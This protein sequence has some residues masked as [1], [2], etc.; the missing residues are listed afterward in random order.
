MTPPAA[1]APASPRRIV[2]AAAAAMPPPPLPPA[3]DETPDEPLPAFLPI[4]ADAPERRRTPTPMRSLVDS[5]V[6]RL[7][8]PAQD[9]WREELDAVW[10]KVVPPAVASAVRPGKW[11][12][13]VLYLFVAN[14]AQLFEIRRLHLRIIETA[15]RRYFDPTRLRQV[16]LLINPD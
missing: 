13:G 7:N 8:L 3:V 6:R 2:R 5:V 11:E 1:A 15:L 12:N 4:D 14:S 10:K 16:R 9:L